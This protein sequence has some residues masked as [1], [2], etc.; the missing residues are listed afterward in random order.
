[1]NPWG[2]KEEGKV[3]LHSKLVKGT[4]RTTRTTEDDTRARKGCGGWMMPGDWSSP[5]ITV[6][7]EACTAP[8][9]PS[10]SHLCF[11][12]WKGRA[13]PSTDITQRVCNR[14]RC[15]F[16]NCWPNTLKTCL[17]QPPMSPNRAVH[18]LEELKFVFHILENEIRK[19]GNLPSSPC[20]AVERRKRKILPKAGA[21][22]HSK[23]FW[24]RGKTRQHHSPL[25]AVRKIY[26]VTVSL[27]PIQQNQG[28]GERL[29]DLNHTL[30][31]Q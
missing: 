27:C 22:A 15:I 12:S 6:A 9:H 20:W 16:N 31:N 8:E 10:L 5:G 4:R 13:S 30:W 2:T 11:C 24:V 28:L 18:W 14:R 25:C 29:Y 19:E 21:V 23:G 17:P 3:P 1:M 26:S 7:L